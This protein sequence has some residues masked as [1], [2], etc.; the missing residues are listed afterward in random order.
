[1]ESIGFIY[2]SRLSTTG[3]HSTLSKQTRC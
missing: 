3:K 1:V 2:A